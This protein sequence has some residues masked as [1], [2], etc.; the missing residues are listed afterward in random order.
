MPTL[1]I[2]VPGECHLNRTAERA[3]L[4]VRVS[5][6]SPKQEEAAEN[7]TNTVNSLHQLFR[8][9]SPKTES[10][11]AT[12]EAAVTLFTIGSISTSSAIPLDD[13]GKTT[14]PRKYSAYAT[15][16]AI[17]RDFAKLS[18][19]ISQLFMMPF[20]EVERIDWRLTEETIQVLAKE[21]QKKALLDAIEKAA[22]YAE[23]VGREVF[24][25]E[26]NDEGGYSSTGRTKQT[27]T[28]NLTRGGQGGGGMDSIDLEPQE[29]VLS[30]SIKTVFATTEW[31]KPISLSLY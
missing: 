16:S 31:K 4:T 3:F 25:V 18:M 30:S 14:G 24:L 1:E 23:V 8:E 22:V 27:N 5:T 13:K 28:R 20:V 11:G 29:I 2:N 9:L 17:F 26:I 10:G 21:A 7:A 19:V 12:P 15:I 6:E